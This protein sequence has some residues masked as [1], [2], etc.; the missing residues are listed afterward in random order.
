MHQQEREKENRDARWLAWSF[1]N[2]SDTGNKQTID[3]LLLYNKPDNKLFYKK[4]RRVSVPEKSLLS[5][6]RHVYM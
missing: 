3:T 6:G 5:Q 1:K 2:H 4:N